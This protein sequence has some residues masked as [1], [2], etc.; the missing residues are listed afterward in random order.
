MPDPRN[1]YAPPKA[2]VADQADSLDPQAG[3]TF[4]PN[5]RRV[6][7]GR[8]AGWIGDAWRFFRARPW[9]WLLTAL[10]VTV[11]W[12]VASWLPL[13]GLATLLLWPFIG[14]GIVMAADAQRRTGTFEL[15]ALFEGFR[16]QPKALLVVGGMYV[17]MQAVLFVCLAVMIGSTFA[18]QAVL[19]IGGSPDPAAVMTPAYALAL[20]FYLAAVLPITAATYLAPPLILFHDLPAGTAMKMSF[21]GSFKN[22]LSGF[23]FSVCAFGLVMIA[24]IPLGLGLIIAIPVLMITTYTVYRDIFIGP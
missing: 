24:A 14:G 12:A 4:I 19:H 15:E 13:A 5:G 18:L 16:R 7:A 22:I 9:M 3:G 20:L 17:L 6:S 21:I 1:P 2:P 8:G 10:L 11:I 23:V